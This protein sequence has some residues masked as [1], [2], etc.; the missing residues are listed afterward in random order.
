MEDTQ[1][2]IILD[3][4]TFKYHGRT[5]IDNVS[6][7]VKSG[8][9]F[10]LLGPSGVGKS[11]LLHLITG[12]LKPSSGD[13]YYRGSNVGNLNKKQL[14]SMRQSMGFLFQ[15]G[16]LFNG[17][18]VLDNVVFPL[19]YHYKL[20]KS[21]VEMHGLLKLEQVGLRNAAH[22]RPHE[23]SGGMSRRVALARA[24]CLDPQMLIYDEPFVG[25]DPVTVR[26]LVKLMQRLMM[27]PGT[28]SFMVTHD[29]KTAITLA[30]KVGVL[31]D[32]KW[33]FLGAPKDMD[34]IN[35]PWL[36]QFIG[37]NDHGPIPFH[38]PGESFEESLS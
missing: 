27:T 21:I 37:D 6:L 24:I 19:R 9:F 15:A 12:H 22:L 7:E 31:S 14:A 20:P 13:I 30:N 10:C 35:D 18:N 28:T 26:V 17:L 2:V 34:A 11:T 25:Q 33:V 5:I 4:V 29:I 23:L 3:K 8:D 36:A 38:Y 32:G 1:D 16:A